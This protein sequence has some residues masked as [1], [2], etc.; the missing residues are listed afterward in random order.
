MHTSINALY[1]FK[2]ETQVHRWIYSALNDFIL[3]WGAANN[4][5]FCDSWV[6]VW[7]RDLCRVQEIQ[8]LTKGYEYIQENRIAAVGLAWSTSTYLSTKLLT[9]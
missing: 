8:M 2:T 3:V 6:R 5:R 9:W 1:N 4:F 7:T